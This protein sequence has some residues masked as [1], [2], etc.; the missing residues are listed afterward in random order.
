M[1]TSGIGLVNA[2]ETI[3]PIIPLPVLNRSE[4]LNNKSGSYSGTL[5]TYMVDGALSSECIRITKED[6]SDPFREE[7]QTYPYFRSKGARKSLLSTYV[8][9]SC[10]CL[11]G[12]AARAGTRRQHARTNACGGTAAR[13]CHQ[14][15]LA[16]PVRGSK[17]SSCC[18]G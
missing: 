18:Q 2:T 14:G 1:V 3:W 8:P 13:P 7:L 15:A 9:M 12:C 4:C 10:G 16:H 5:C 17:S 11:P 6:H